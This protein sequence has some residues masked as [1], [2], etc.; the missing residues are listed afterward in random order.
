MFAARR[1]GAEQAVLA[2]LD[3]TFPHIGWKHSTGA[4]LVSRVAEHG[5]RRA[6]EMREVARTL[7]DIGIAPT[8]ADRDGAAARRGGAEMA[9]AGV[10]YPTDGKFSWRA[11]ADALAP[12]RN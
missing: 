4:Y 12:G 7:E 10:T 9:D 1:F 11:L 5:K 6:D 3:K 8:M 2:S